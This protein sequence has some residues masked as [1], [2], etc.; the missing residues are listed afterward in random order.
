MSVNDQLKR[1][2]IADAA[3]AKMAEQYL[4]LK[5]VDV[6]DAAGFKA[7]HDARMVVKSR[8]V[9]VE[10]VRKELKADAL[11]YGRKVDA[12][13]K[14]ITALL[15]P[16]ET[17]L[18]DEENA[19]RAEQERI[20]NEARLKVEAE[21]RA[22]KEAEEAARK[23]EQE[24]IRKEQEAE[25]ARLQTERDKIEA[26][27]REIEEERRKAQETIEAERRKVEEEKRRIAE[28]EAAK[29]RQEELELAKAEAAERAKKETEERL[30]REAAE[31]KAKAIAEENAS[32]VAEAARPDREK[33]ATVANC[34]RGVDVPAMSTEQGAA[35]AARVHEIIRDAAKR[36][37][38]VASSDWSLVRGFEEALA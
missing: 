2:D 29:R 20:K 14:R 10:K 37:D 31:A 4:P 32:K 9:E 15:E 7:V 27:R 16:I 23:A 33:L 38:N 12:E 24:R 18:Q 5:I 28:A 1:F 30:A 13:A 6:T 17:H 3:I 36:I 26:E 8:R 25:A 35:A 22:R 11:E 34:V 21:E 19:Y